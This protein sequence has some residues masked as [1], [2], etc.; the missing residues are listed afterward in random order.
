[1][2][3]LGIGSGSAKGRII[4]RHVERNFAIS[5]GAALGDFLAAVSA[6]TDEELAA[7]RSLCHDIA[8]TH[9]RNTPKPRSTS[10]YKVNYRNRAD[11]REAARLEILRSAFDHAGLLIGHELEYRKL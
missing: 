11:R 5:C 9:S 6:A 3:G 2:Q 8:S 7:T 1:M 10:L 4:P